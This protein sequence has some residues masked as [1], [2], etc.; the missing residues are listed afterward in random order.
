MIRVCL[1]RHAPTT[2]NAEGRVQG[3]TDV[4]LSAEGRALAATW[5]LPPGFAGTPCRASPLQRAIQTAAILGCTDPA[6]EPRL[7][8]MNWGRCEGKTLAELRADPSLGFEAAER[9]GLDFRPPDGESPRE[10]AARLRAVLHDVAL[11]DDPAVTLVAHKGLLRAALVLA[12]GWTML[13]P[14]AVSVEGDR[15]LVLGVER[16]AGGP[17][18]SVTVEL[19]DSPGLRP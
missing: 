3:L 11:G 6:L 8:E 13:G 14:A 7:I 1:L 12:T 9:R 18:G 10:V 19:L 2:W 17:P 4:P 16:P 15:A 5:R